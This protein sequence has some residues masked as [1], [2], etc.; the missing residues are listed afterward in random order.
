MR[1]RRPR[2]RSMIASTGSRAREEE[3]E[4][5]VASIRACRH[6]AENTPDRPLPHEPRPV[7][8]VS[9]TARLAIAG[10]A[11]GTRVHATGLPFND[12][13]GDRLRAWLALSPDEFYDETRVAIIPMG[14]CFPGQDSKGGDLPPRKECA[15]LWRRPLFA[16]LP[17][18]EMI[19]LVGIYAQRWHLGAAAEKSLTETV[20]RWREIGSTSKPVAIPLPHPSWRNNGWLRKNP[21]FEEEL[22]P[23]MRG[24]IRSVLVREV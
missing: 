11:P 7:L 1:A 9:T 4:S 12:A 24:E 13:S 6:C 23:W 22:L 20:R 16:H 17:Q 8:R 19:L 3:L 14:F 18:L 10:Q 21:W 2:A 5:L 15:E